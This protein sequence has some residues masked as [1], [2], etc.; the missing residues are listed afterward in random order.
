MSRLREIIDIL[1]HS[2]HSNPKPL[3]CPNCIS[4]K[5]KLKESYGILPRIY[6]CEECGY[7]GHIILELEP[8]EK[9]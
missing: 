5:I 3:F 7:E 6:H 8:E 4:L 9:P 2:K 1:K